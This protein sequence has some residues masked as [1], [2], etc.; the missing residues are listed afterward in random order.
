MVSL[1]YMRPPPATLVA[2]MRS[3]HLRLQ[4]DTQEQIAQAAS[5]LQGQEHPA[6][7]LGLAPL[8]ISSHPSVARWA[9]KKINSVLDRLDEGGIL[10]LAS[11]GR[12]FDVPDSPWQQKWRDLQPRDVRALEA[13]ADT[14]VGVLGLA[15]MHSSGYV[16]QKSIE[17]LAFYRGKLA[18]A[19][20]LVRINDWVKPVRAAA[21]LAILGRLLE[22]REGDLGRCQELLENILLTDRIEHWGRDDHRSIREAIDK[23]LMSAAFGAVME[24][25]LS[26]NRSVLRGRMYRFA[27]ERDANSP[28]PILMRAM[29]SRMNTHRLWAAREATKRL[30]GD[31]LRRIV[32]LMRRDSQA[33]IRYEAVFALAVKLPPVDPAILIESLVDPSHDVRF[34]ACHYL[35]KHGFDARAHYLRALSSSGELELAA[36][37][38]GIGEKGKSGDEAGVLPLLSHHD[39]NVRAAAV[40]TVGKLGRRDDMNWLVAALRDPHKFVVRAAA[41]QLE[42]R[43]HIVDASFMNGWYWA[44]PRLSLKRR[45]IRLGA[46]MERWE[47]LEFLLGAVHHPE[48]ILCR[49]VEFELVRWSQRFIDWYA[50][51]KEARID[52]LQNA[53]AAARGLVGDEV[54]DWVARKI[55]ANRKR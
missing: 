26:F 50:A 34:L 35:A 45:A 36:I 32:E 37:V 25:G 23:T 43:M 38:A 13:F 53:V 44:E 6:V 1:T 42:E 2:S 5:E 52:R 18:F 46:R 8:T 7:A 16:R 11:Q 29:T 47:A 9:A 41:K 3:L 33:I 17:R 31:E 30:S 39:P 14:S 48:R 55:V 54:L 12:H 40:Y 27:L 21:R 4:S 22:A 10:W 28:A 15:S 51:P 24:Q 19:F 49:D 20:L